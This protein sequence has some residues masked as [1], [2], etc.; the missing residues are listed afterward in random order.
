MAPID[1][2]KSEM[3]D[4][5]DPSENKGDEKVESKKPLSMTPPLSPRVTF[6]TPRHRSKSVD[7]LSPRSGRQKKLEVITF[8]KLREYLNRTLDNDVLLTLSDEKLK[9]VNDYLILNPKKNVFIKKLR[10]LDP[11]NILDQTKKLSESKKTEED[12]EVTAAEEA[13]YQEVIVKVQNEFNRV[14]QALKPQIDAISIIASKTPKED[15]RSAYNRVVLTVTTALRDAFI[16]YYNAVDLEKTEEKAKLFINK[17]ESIL[18]K[19][20]LAQD[21]AGK[22]FVTQVYAELV[23]ELGVL[24]DKETKKVE[25]ELQRERKK[26]IDD[27][28]LTRN[29]KTSQFIDSTIKELQSVI[30][31]DNA[32]FLMRLVNANDGFIKKL[33][34]FDKKKNIYSADRFYEVL[35]ALCGMAEL[36]KINKKLKDNEFFLY[37]IENLNAPYREHDKLLVQKLSETRDFIK[38]DIQSRNAVLSAI[39]RKADVVYE[40]NNKTNAMMTYSHKNLKAELNFY[41]SS[42]EDPYYND[43]KRYWAKKWDSYLSKLF[44]DKN[45]TNFFIEAEFNKFL[46]LMRSVISMIGDLDHLKRFKNESLSKKTGPRD[47]CANLIMRVMQKFPDNASTIFDEI[48]TV[49]RDHLATIHRFDQRQRDELPRPEDIEDPNM[50]FSNT[51]YQFVQ[52]AKVLGVDSTFYAEEE[53]KE[54]KQN[55]AIEQPSPSSKERVTHDEIK[56]EKVLDSSD[57]ES[58]NSDH[59]SGFLLSKLPI[60]VPINVVV[61]SGPTLQPPVTN[62]EVVIPV[63]EKQQT[64]LD[65]HDMP[66]R[67][68]GVNAIVQPTIVTA[69]DW[70]DNPKKMKSESHQAIENA[71]ND[72][73]SSLSQD[74]MKEVKQYWTRKWDK[75]LGEL[76]SDKNATNAFIESEFA[77]LLQ[78]TSIVTRILDN[79]GHLKRLKTGDKSK[80]T[81]PDD[82]CA[83]LLMSVMQKY[84]GNS[85]TILSDIKTLWQD[86]LKTIHEF[87]Q[88][89]LKTL[90][91]EE[92]MADPTM[93]FGSTYY[94]YVEIAREFNKHPV[95]YVD[96]EAKNEIVMPDPTL[97]L[98]TTDAVTNKTKDEEKIPAVENDNSEVAE[99][100]DIDIDFVNNDLSIVRNAHDVPNADDRAVTPPVVAG[101]IHWLGKRKTVLKQAK[102]KLDD[103]LQKIYPEGNVK[104]LKIWENKWSEAYDRLIAQKASTETI[105]YEF[106]QLQKVV[107]VAAIILMNLDE[108][109]YQSRKS[110]DNRNEPAKIACI[111]QIMS[112]LNQYPNNHHSILDDLKV[113]WNKNQQLIHPQYENTFLQAIEDASNKNYIPPAQHQD[114]FSVFKILNAELLDDGAEKENAFIPAAIEVKEENKL[115]TPIQFIDNYIPEPILPLYVDKYLSLNEKSKHFQ[116]KFDN[117]EHLVSHA[118]SD[119]LQ[120]KPEIRNHFV[121]ILPDKIKLNYFNPKKIKNSQYK[122][123]KGFNFATGLPLYLNATRQVESPLLDVNG[124]LSTVVKEYLPKGHEALLTIVKEVFAITRELVYSPTDKIQSWIPNLIG[125]EKIKNAENRLGTDFLALQLQRAIA[126]PLLHMTAEKP[127]PVDD[128]ISMAKTIVFAQFDSQIRLLNDLN[129]LALD[130]D[131]HAEDLKSVV[132]VVAAEMFRLANHFFNENPIK[133]NAE[134]AYIVE[135]IKWV[136]NDEKPVTEK[137]SAMSDI[138]IKAMDLSRKS[139]EYAVLFNL[140]NLF[141]TKMKNVINNTIKANEQK[142]MPSEDASEESIPMA[143]SPPSRSISFSS[144]SSQW[145]SDEADFSQEHGQDHIPLSIEIPQEA[146]GMITEPAPEDLREPL[147]PISAAIAMGMPN[148]DKSLRYIPIQRVLYDSPEKIGQQSSAPPS[149]L[150]SPIPPPPPPMDSPSNAIFNNFIPVMPTVLPVS[151]MAVDSP[152]GSLSSR[153][154]VPP[155]PEDSPRHVVRSAFVPVTPSSS[156]VSPPSPSSS[157]DVEYD[158]TPKSIVSSSTPSPAALQAN[159]KRGFFKESNPLSQPKPSQ[160]N[161]GKRRYTPVFTAV[162]DFIAESAKYALK[163]KDVR[164]SIKAFDRSNMGQYFKSNSDEIQQA[165]ANPDKITKIKKALQ[166]TRYYTVATI[167]DVERTAGLTHA[168]ALRA[169]PAVSLD[170]PILNSEI[171]GGADLLKPNEYAVNFVK[172]QGSNKISSSFIEHLN[173]SGSYCIYAGILPPSMEEEKYNEPRFNEVREFGSITIPSLEHLRAAEKILLRYLSEKGTQKPLGIRYQ[174]YPPKAELFEAM[175]LM[176]EKNNISYVINN[177]PGSALDTKYESHHHPMIKRIFEYLD[178]NFDPILTRPNQKALKTLLN[179]L[180]EKWRTHPDLAGFV[181]AVKSGKSPAPEHLKKLFDKA[182]VEEEPGLMDRITRVI[183]G[184]R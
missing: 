100:D 46:G 90:P 122:F 103:I 102:Q 176:C 151:S 147:S 87:S 128:L 166:N 134:L 170:T 10:A 62:K 91:T 182:R 183:R 25:K 34:Y 11:K 157:T 67:D 110:R 168:Q 174:A 2:P 85:D 6:Q 63:E 19:I 70:I 162:M 40:W 118:L 105:E 88:N 181:Q 84:P 131:N 173:S 69:R 38:Y 83:N 113:I 117:F 64:I 175:I 119:V 152:S 96:N 43:V 1:T 120:G 141:N 178:D 37:Y 49:W 28:A 144:R 106:N 145:S 108:E 143:P 155:P 159:H 17:I 156:S 76:L 14:Y 3:N 127:K 81:E 18:N 129:K 9:D 78:L 94:H 56:E 30:C 58:L 137:F 77:K 98:S 47:Q 153:S 136:V 80:K 45:A 12:I 163:D 148:Q 16:K 73:F 172:E 55:S 15:L 35:E 42:E 180:P 54:A 135:R 48:R 130:S 149:P 74:Y 165:S 27:S 61:T 23:K 150:S 65:T 126:Q 68:R 161:Q 133:S 107:E 179:A 116:K 66:M 36:S 5:P 89:Q 41:F 121:R 177:N 97:P 169:V 164:D 154:S 24:P 20:T 22:K 72:Y 31:D 132:K 7:I 50:K 13:L 112:V 71:V 44:S 184:R 82:V 52:I 109:T 33:N 146:D 167:P 114:Y 93:S 51:Y 125:D 29:N 4:T 142:N 79:L 115:E 59:G 124:G 57:S 32:E 111:N 26:T 99:I 139:G 123:S 101:D 140:L 39:G 86:N 138:Q 160:P 104:V 95:I 21:T 75:Y 53:K 158:Q 8:L 171:G 60:G 92:E